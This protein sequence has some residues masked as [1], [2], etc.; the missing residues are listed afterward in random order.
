MTR[1][2]IWALL[3][4]CGLVLGVAT[5]YLLVRRA[6]REQRAAQATALP[7]TVLAEVISGPRL[8]FRHTG[9]GAA[10]GKTAVV[11]LADPTGPRAY[12]D[13]TCE[14]LYAVASRTVCLYR[15]AGVVTTYHAALGGPAFDSPTPLSIVG[16]P[17]RARL[18]T[19][20]VWVATTTFVTGDSYLTQGFATRTYVTSTADG[21]AAHVEDFTLIHQGQQIAPV[22]R[23]YWGVTFAADDRT[24]YLTAAWGGQ[25][26]LAQGDLVAR[27]VTT[28]APNVEC[29][30]LS[31]DGTRVAFKKR[32]GTAADP[33]RL[34]VRDLATG[35]ESPTAEQR[36]LDDQV[37]WLDDRTIGYA[38]ARATPGLATSDIWS[39][40]ADGTGAP[41]LLVADAFSPAVV[42]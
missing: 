27:T 2:R 33:W 3:A 38:L 23:N 21:V 31:P 5:A 17:S 8:Y 40:P 39:V 29:P 16:F 12:L 26:W 15:D 10:Y 1:R 32:V 24:V 34:M 28:I 18:S 7:T 35:V 11:S 41:T 20:G 4:T 22:D 6:D 36:S 13:A 37:I 30:S 19:D 25:T 9:L 14:R 42:R